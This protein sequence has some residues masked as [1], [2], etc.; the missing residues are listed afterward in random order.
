MK[1]SKFSLSHYKLLT[2]NMGK[3][4]PM[5]CIEALPGDTIQQ[6]TSALIRVSPLVAP[7]MHPVKVRIHHWF[8]PHRLVWDDWEDFITGGPSNDD[9]TTFPTIDLSSVTRGSLADY[10]GVPITGSSVAVSALPFRA[11]ALIWNQFYADQ[12]LDTQLTIDTTDGPDSTTST[13]LKSVNWEKDYFTTAR[14]WTQKGSAVSLPIG[15]VAPV[16]TNDENIR[17]KGSTFT[18]REMTTQ[19]SGYVAPDTGGAS[20]T[21]L[22]FGT[23]SGLEADLSNAT[24]ATI[25]ELRTAFAMQSFAENRARFGSRFVEYLRSLGVRSSDRD[26]ET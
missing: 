9:P 12:D 25:N 7:V 6:A 17:M 20:S 18:D 1:R 10:L 14:P 23:E 21:Y 4:I 5:G 11:Y 15:T 24:A 16:V 3:L 13:T 2:C 26:W 19:G 8:V 22:R